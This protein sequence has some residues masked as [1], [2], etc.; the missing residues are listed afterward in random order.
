[1]RTRTTLWVAALAAAVLGGPAGALWAADADPYDQSGVP[2][3]V[4]PT[5]PALSQ[6]S[7]T[8]QAVHGAGAYRAA[9]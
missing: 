6:P 3:E 5:D 4:Q 7:G 2:L 1:M 9:A 8:S